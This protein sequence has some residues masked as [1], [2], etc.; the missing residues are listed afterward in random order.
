MQLRFNAAASLAA[1]TLAA[2]L[3]ATMAPSVYAQKATQPAGV[4]LNTETGS[5]AGR[6]QVKMD[7]KEFMRT[8]EWDEERSVWVDLPPRKSKK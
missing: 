3:A 5:P 2:T 8:H 6:S 1:L 4:P 7:T